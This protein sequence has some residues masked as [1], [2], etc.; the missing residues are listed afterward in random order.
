MAEIRVVTCFLDELDTSD[1][2]WKKSYFYFFIFYGKGPY[3][4]PPLMENSITLIFFLNEAFPKLS[5]LVSL[6]SNQTAINLSIGLVSIK[7][8]EGLAAMDK[9]DLAPTKHQR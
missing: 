6:L 3:P 7:L 9:E 1:H 5:L 2:F 8:K 4:L